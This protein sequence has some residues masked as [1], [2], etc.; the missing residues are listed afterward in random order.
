VNLKP[1]GSKT[2]I[3]NCRTFSTKIKFEMLSKINNK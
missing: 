3:V 1:G 2:S